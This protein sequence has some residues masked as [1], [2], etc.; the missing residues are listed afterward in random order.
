M[1]GSKSEATDHIEPHCGRLEVFE[2]LANHI[3]LCHV[4]HNTVTGKFDMGYRPGNT[5]EE[6]IKWMNSERAKNEVLHSRNFKKP[7]VIQYGK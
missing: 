6:K 1:C 7:R 2:R 5:I 3:A 4:C